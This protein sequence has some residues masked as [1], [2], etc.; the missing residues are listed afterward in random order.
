MEG[1]R[2]ATKTYPVSRKM[3]HDA[4]MQRV[5]LLNR[6]MYGP[7][8][9]ELEELSDAL[10]AA[11]YGRVTGEQ[12]GIIQRAAAQFSAYRDR[13]NAGRTVLRAND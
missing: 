8:T 3:L 4:E 11:Q 12:Y 13:L 2:M 9:P 6:H 5:R 10:C 7:D 1:F